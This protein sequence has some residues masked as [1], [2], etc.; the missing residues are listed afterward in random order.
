MK[1]ERLR[2]YMK[3]A[4]DE[5][6]G[7]PGEQEWI[8]YF[9]GSGGPE[10]RSRQE[11][12]LADC[13]NCQTMLQDIRDFEASGPALPIDVEGDYQAVQYRLRPRQ[14]AISWLLQ[15]AAVIMALG[16]T[17]L[18]AWAWQLHKQ[19]DA[20]VVRLREAETNIAALSK[21]PATPPFSPAAVQAVELL[22]LEFQQRSGSG[23]VLPQITATQGGIATLL[24]N[25]DRMPRAAQAI[26]AR[27]TD[28]EG[29]VLWEGSGLRRSTDGFVPLSLLTGS[30]HPGPYHVEIFVNG[31]RVIYVFRVAESPLDSH[32]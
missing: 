1:R 6:N 10:R 20:L 3:A 23:P 11:A 16:L 7:C 24:L 31:A 22:P 8:E 14:P 15:A 17:A 18:G 25:A 26:S 2:A 29:K 4:M 28:S 21:T 13:A 30:L 12:H 32:Q 19:R 9:C 5:T 27:L